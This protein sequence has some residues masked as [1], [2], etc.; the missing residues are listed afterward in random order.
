MNGCFGEGL[1]IHAA[2]V[3]SL[4]GKLWRAAGVPSEPNPHVS[5]FLNFPRWAFA[6]SY[7]LPDALV[8]RATMLAARSEEHRAAM[9]AIAET[10]PYGSTHDFQ[11][12]ID[13]VR[14]IENSICDAND[15]E[16][17]RGTP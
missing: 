7:L 13:Y 4:Y 17:D 12:L 6:I 14:A 9:L 2:H 10:A 1:G 5:G 3:D 11:P 15:P 16:P 8:K